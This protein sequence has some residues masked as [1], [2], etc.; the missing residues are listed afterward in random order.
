MDKMIQP[1]LTSFMSVRSGLKGPQDKEGGQSKPSNPFKTQAQGQ[2]LPEEANTDSLG[3]FGEGGGRPWV[4]LPGSPEHNLLSE[5]RVGN[6]GV[7]H[8][9]GKQ[10]AGMRKDGSLGRKG[11]GAPEGNG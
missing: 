2:G 5:A 10:E 11:K 1:T 8:R 9:P 6:P 4:T 3:E 7:G